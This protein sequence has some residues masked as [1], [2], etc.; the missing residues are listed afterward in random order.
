MDASNRQQLQDKTDRGL[1]LE[2]KLQD[3]ESLHLMLMREHSSLVQVH[4]ATR[5]ELDIL[6]RANEELK[7]QHDHKMQLLLQE[8]TQNQQQLHELQQ[9]LQREQIIGH[10]A[11]LAGTEVLQELARLKLEMSGALYLCASFTNHLSVSRCIFQR[12]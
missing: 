2:R 9:S 6:K 3:I 5:T 8:S 11:I 7:P 1:E 10:D 12:G 4:E